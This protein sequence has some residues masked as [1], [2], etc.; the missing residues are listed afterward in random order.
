MVPHS[1]PHGTAASPI[2]A[3]MYL[4]GRRLYY[5][6]RFVSTHHGDGLAVAHTHKNQHTQTQHTQEI[7]LV[8][9]V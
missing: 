1:A 4:I 5:S 9:C 7:A 2:I 3:L 6:A 8:A